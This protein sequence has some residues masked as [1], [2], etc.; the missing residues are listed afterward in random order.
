MDSITL[1]Q[2]LERDRI[3]I[4]T[5]HFRL[6]ASANRTSRGHHRATLRMKMHIACVGKRLRPTPANVQ[7]TSLLRCNQILFQLQN[8]NR[9]TVCFIPNV[10][11][12]SIS[13][14]NLGHSKEINIWNLY[15]PWT[16]SLLWIRVQ[17]ERKAFAYRQNMNGQ[18]TVQ[19][20][21]SKGYRKPGNVET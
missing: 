7:N 15:Y 20:C 14:L 6:K 12:L 13:K 16:S 4:A 9:C 19:M 2:E 5:S 11:W 3:E 18:V 1:Q 10:A 21:R 17:T 8:I